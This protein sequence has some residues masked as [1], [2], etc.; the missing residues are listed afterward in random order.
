MS[1]R[2]VTRKRSLQDSTS[3][4]SNELDEFDEGVDQQYGRESKKNGYGCDDDAS[5]YQRA[6]KWTLDE[7]TLANQLVSDFENG[8]LEDC[9]DGTTLRSYLA[10]KL[11]CAPMR[12]SKK[13]AGRCIGKVRQKQDIY[14]DF[15]MY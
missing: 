9:E 6:G 11:C 3:S 1:N 5:N 15:C 14:D 13:F 12:I 8:A 7:E 10:R 4:S 2:I